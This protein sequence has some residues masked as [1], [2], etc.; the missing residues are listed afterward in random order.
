MPRTAPFEKHADH[1]DQWFEDNSDIYLAELE[2][3]RQLMPSHAANGLE[4]GVGSGKFA[5][6]LGIQTGVEPAEEMAA[7][8]EKLGIRVYR[9]VAEALPF[10][11]AAFDFV[12]MVTTICFVDDIQL[13]F[14]EAF[15]VI[16]PGGCIL[17][18]FVDRES[19][20]GRRYMDRRDESLFY[21]DATFFSSQEVHD[22]LIQAGFE[23]LTAR[24]TLI[25]GEPK[26]TIEDG[27]G[28][29]AFVVLRGLKSK[30]L[31]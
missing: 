8:A 12:L 11:D 4:V 28:K 26:E 18:G 29:G 31:A 23:D 10:T 25:P 13:S 24:Q 9:N 15:R 2:A 16:Q 7:R 17:V 30:S 14:R 1:Y 3:V 6:P 20:L 22:Y 27:F 21:K 5:A 19:E